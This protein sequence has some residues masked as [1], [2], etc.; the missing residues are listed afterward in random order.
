MTKPVTNEHVY[1]TP[2]M[3]GSTAYVWGNQKY[4]LSLD[5][6][7]IRMKGRGG[8]PGASQWTVS[9]PLLH[10][11]LIYALGCA[12]VLNV[13]DAKTLKVV[14]T[15]RLEMY[16]LLHYNAVGATPSVALGGKHIFLMDN[17][18]A[19]FVIEPGR[20][21]KQ[22]AHNR[23]ETAMRHPWP[24]TT[25]ERFESSPTFAG[26]QMFLRGEEYLYCIGDRGSDRR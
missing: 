16:P 2:V 23:I 19:T 22:V 18:G 6:E 14:Y 1:S 24:L 4:E 26:K 13:V 3:D 10:D 5:G 12:G 15:R 21:F 20:I 11:G 25:L 17:Q 9:S 8:I 7:E